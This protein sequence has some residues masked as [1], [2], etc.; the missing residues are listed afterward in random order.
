MQLILRSLTFFKH[1]EPCIY[2]CLSSYAKVVPVPRSYER[3][4]DYRSYERERIRRSVLRNGNL[5]RVF[6]S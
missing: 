1:I 6:Y 2:V 4:R 5:D 3:E